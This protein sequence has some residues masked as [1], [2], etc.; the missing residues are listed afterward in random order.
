MN[1]YTNKKTKSNRTFKSDLFT[2]L[3][4]DV[5]FI[6]Q[7]CMLVIT[8]QLAQNIDRDE[9]ITTAVKYCIANHILEEFLTSH[10]SEVAE[11]MKFQW[12]VDDVIEAERENARQEGEEKHSRLCKMLLSQ[13]RMEDLS[14][15]LDDEAFRQ[16][17]YEEF[18]IV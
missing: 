2:T 10:E 18:H 14:K 17:L 3:R 13:G 8:E 5:A 15:S 1:T 11:M 12:T 6:M 9:A 16:Q 7:R 4:D